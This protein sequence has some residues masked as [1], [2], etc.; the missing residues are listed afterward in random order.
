MKCFRMLT[1]IRWPQIGILLVVVLALTCGCAKKEPGEI[2]IGAIFALT[3]DY[4]AFGERA[5]NGVELALEEIKME[6]AVGSNIEIIYEDSEGDPDKALSAFRRLVEVEGV[7]LILGPLSSAEL[8]SIAPLAERKEIVVLSP[9]ASAPQ[10]TTAGDYIFRNCVSDVFE[11]TVA[12]DFAYRILR[13]TKASVIYLN[14]DFGVGLKNAFKDRFGHIGGQTIAEEAFNS[15]DIDF[16]TQLTKINSKKPDVVVLAG[17]AVEM[18]RILRQSVELGLRCTFVS[19]SSFEAPEILRIG[20]T[21][22]EG[23]YYTYQGFDSQ[24]EEETV[25][26]FVARYKARYAE[27]P[28]IFAGLSFDAMRIMSEALRIGGVDANRVKEALYGIEG[29]HGVVGKTSFDENGDVIKP[30]GVK[31]V[32][33]GEFVWVMRDFEISL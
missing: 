3:G 13:K 33:D 20:G 15:G 22:T 1:T 25:R 2:R 11:G 32:V 5:K 7:K 12:A 16:R 28:D 10:I 8:L 14:D 24:S 6:S 23:V 19:F 18:G 30:I 26:E 9:V 29:F 4:A 21:G 31:R 27:E 17:Y